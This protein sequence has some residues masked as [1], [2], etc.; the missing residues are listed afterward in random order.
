MPLPQ[1]DVQD[2]LYQL[3]Q[4]EREIQLLS[5]S[6]PKFDTKTRHHLSPGVEKVKSFFSK[7]STYVAK[8]PDAL[9][10]KYIDSYVKWVNQEGPS[11]PDSPQTIRALSDPLPNPVPRPYHALKFSLSCSPTQNN[12]QLCKKWSEHDRKLFVHQY[13][14]FPKRFHKIA[15]N[16]SLKTSEDCVLYYY[17]RKKQLHLKQKLFNRQPY[18]PSRTHYLGEK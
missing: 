6:P 16:L 9:K 15:L 11:A 3:E 13:L 17:Q 12:P 10:K 7:H 1:D 8:H 18:M 14:A 4:T 5:T 2:I